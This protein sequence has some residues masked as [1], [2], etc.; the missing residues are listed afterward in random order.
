MAAVSSLKA[1]LAACT[2][3]VPTLAWAESAPMTLTLPQGSTVSA[4]PAANDSSSPASALDPQNL[5]SPR[6]GGRKQ[7]TGHAA[8][9][10]VR[11]AHRRHRPSQRLYA[12]HR[13]VE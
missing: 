7:G 3:A 1:W 8:R 5:S 13:R 6:P 10:R 2:L 9:R 4:L 11:P 12:D